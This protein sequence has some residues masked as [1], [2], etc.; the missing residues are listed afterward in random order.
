MSPVIDLPMAGQDA[1]QRLE[2]L[3]LTAKGPN[4]VTTKAEAEG[5]S[6]TINTLQNF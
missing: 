2:Q 1:R 3:Y 5:C 4:F 6:K